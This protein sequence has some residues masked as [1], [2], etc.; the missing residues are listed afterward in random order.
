MGDDVEALEPLERKNIMLQFGNASKV[1]NYYS[2]K[3]KTQDDEL[4]DA[5]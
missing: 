4:R 1:T 2:I 5:L 3:Q